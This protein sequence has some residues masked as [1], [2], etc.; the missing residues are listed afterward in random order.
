MF[1]I[2]VQYSYSYE[3]LY[4]SKQSKLNCFN[5]DSLNIN[6]GGKPVETV[7]DVQYLGDFINRDKLYSIEI[8]NRQFK[9]SAINI[10]V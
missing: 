1:S 6:H 9:M 8:L 4:N 3:I 5:V 2:C 7:E 10:T